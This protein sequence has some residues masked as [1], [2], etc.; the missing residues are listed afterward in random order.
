MTKTGGKCINLGEVTSPSPVKDLN[1]KSYKI[2]QFC[3]NDFAG[4]PS[5]IS[6][7]LILINQQLYFSWE[8]PGFL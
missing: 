6:E 1:Y 4:E 5:K 8:I 2:H 7:S 3:T